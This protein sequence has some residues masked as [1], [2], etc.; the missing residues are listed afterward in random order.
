N[1]QGIDLQQLEDENLDARLSAMRTTMITHQLP[2]G[3]RLLDLLE[4]A[5]GPTGQQVV[6]VRYLISYDSIDARM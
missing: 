2:D 3:R 6:L 4:P 1:F 5:F